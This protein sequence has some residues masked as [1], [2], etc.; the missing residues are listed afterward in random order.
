MKLLLGGLIFSLLATGSALAAKPVDYLSPTALAVTHDGK[1]M[2]V[3]CGTAN[4]VLRFD[5]AR[6]KV[7]GSITMPAAP[8]GLVLSADDKKLYVTCAAP[9]SEVCIIDVSKRKIVGTIAAGHTAA[10]PVLSP[11]GRTLYVCNQF[12]N[13]ISVIDLV[14]RREVRRIA[15]QREPVAEDIT[16]DGKY[17]LVANHLSE[18]ASNLKV[19]AAVV[20]VIDVAAGKVITELDLPVGSEMLKD[21]RVSPDGK[22]AVLTHIFCNYDLPTRRVELGLINANAMTIIDLSNIGILYTFLLDT[23][24]SGAGNP[25]G[26]AWSADS[27]TLVVAHAG[28]Q[29]ASIINFPALLAGLPDVNR[30]ALWPT[31][32]TTPVLKFVPHYEDEELNDGLP[33]LVGARQR[34][35]LPPDDLGPRAIALSGH[36]VYT[37]NYFSDNL[38][39]IDLTTSQPQAV[40]VSLGPKK[41]MT[42]ARKGEFYFHDASICYQGWESC[43]SCHPGGGRVDALNWDLASEGPGHP[44]NTRSILFSDKT[45]PMPDVKGFAPGMGT[46]MESAVRV[47]IKTLLFTNLPDEVASDMDEYIKSLKPVPSPYLIHGQL[48]SA[49]ERGKILFTQ[50]NCASCHVPG[51]YTDQRAHNIGTVTRYDTSAEFRTPTLI[52]AWRT[53]PYL[54]MGSAATVRDVLTDCNPKDGRHGDVADLSSQQIDDLCAYVLSL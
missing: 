11:D 50:A 28:T 22:Y 19:V 34:I 53:G 49:A 46:S 30:K 35:K 9:E 37:A 52:E 20:S 38:S 39:A 3:A 2:F 25:W 54:H 27:T 45:E 24:Y 42:A 26:V 8:S 12:D 1:I 43:S 47:A 36:T 21:L 15:V 5:T 32:Q 51:L 13:D 23:P 29:E 4:R 48:S 10:A 6:K 18:M 33:F 14:A 40:S 16:K 41:E 44:K 31:N 17:L 7:L